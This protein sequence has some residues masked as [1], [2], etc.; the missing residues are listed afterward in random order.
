MTEQTAILEF[1]A[2]E[3]E[4]GLI[5]LELNS[6]ENEG[7]T[8]FGEDEEAHFLLHIESTLEILDIKPTSGAV[9][10]TGNVQQ[11]RD[12]QLLFTYE[13]PSAELAYFPAEDAAKTWYGN[14]SNPTLSGRVLTANGVLPGFGKF[15]YNVNFLSY[16]YTP[17][18]IEFG[19][20]LD[21]YPVRV[22]VRYQAK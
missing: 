19:E 4:F 16:K 17:P 5:K 1:G 13:N 10:F 12:E 18:N 15:V 3:T 14:D 21:E 9:S 2:T 11:E 6:E 22:V 8:V 7:K 20:G